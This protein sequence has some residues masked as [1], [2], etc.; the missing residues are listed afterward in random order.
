MGFAQEMKDFTA[1]FKVGNDAR[2]SWDKPTKSWAERKYETDE[3]E[4]KKAEDAS[5]TA[6]TTRKA[7]T[8]TPGSDYTSGSG[9]L[10][11]DGSPSTKDGTVA[12]DN[13]DV[14]NRFINTVKSAGLTNPYGLAAV[15][16]TAKAESSFKPTAVAG[17]WSDPSESGVPGTSGGLMSWRD[18]RLNNMNNFVSKAGGNSPEAQAK[19]FVNEDPQLIEKLQSAKST[20]EASKLMA[21]AWKYRGYD[22]DDHPENARRLDYTNKYYSRFAP[23]SAAALPTEGT[24]QTVFAAEGGL[25]EKPS[26]QDYAGP[27]PEGEWANTSRMPQMTPGSEPKGALPVDV[28]PAAQAP[29]EDTTSSDR[30]GSGG[31]YN[32]RQFLSPDVRNEAIDAGM[33]W[34]QEHFTGGSAIGQA[35]P[36]RSKK[37]EAFARNTDVAS[38]EDVK[39]ADKAIDPKGELE[40]HLRSMARLNGAYE[41]YLKK[42]D[43][44][45]AAAVAASMM[46]YARKVAMSGGTQ[47]QA[48]I[49]KGNLA[50]AAKVASRVY[51]ELPNGNKLDIKPT[52]DGKALEYKVFDVDG[53]PTDGG[54]MAID[55]FM[56][57]ATGLQ[58][59]TAWFQSMGYYGGQARSQQRGTG[60][61]VNARANPNPRAPAA[62]KTTAAERTALAEKEAAAA[63]DSATNGQI[64]GKAGALATNTP[65]LTP[66]RSNAPMNA[67]ALPVELGTVGGVPTSGNM[68]QPREWDNKMPVEGETIPYNA[69]TGIQKVMPAEGQSP[70][71]PEEQMASTM[72]TNTERT[73]KAQALAGA[74]VQDRAFATADKA[75]KEKANRKNVRTTDSPSS[76][77]ETSASIE[78][79]FMGGATDK[80]GEPAKMP[81]DKRVIVTSI[82]A[83]IMKG[84]EGIDPESA[85]RIVKDILEKGPAM[86]PDGSVGPRGGGDSVFLDSSSIRQLISAY[87]GKAQGVKDVDTELTPRTYKMPSPAASRREYSDDTVARGSAEVQRARSKN[88]A[89]AGKAIGEAFGNM[90]RNTP[91]PSP[92]EPDRT[93]PV[94]PPGVFEPRK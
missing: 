50:G 57:L 79:G 54:R 37:M 21:Q 75:Y 76:R 71:G 4:R 10:D 73:K 78:S 61:R 44:Q 89:A 35:D 24:E 80:D 3:A 90:A 26:E 72:A 17:T 77:T 38:P 25:I 56:E 70:P 12:S 94:R 51:E 69:G 28:K 52:K 16:G 46:S 91:Q 39:E 47:I 30:A 9:A 11:T 2:N 65:D 43:P 22:R 13:S 23:K 60:N 36:D 45:K 55:Q 87:G 15:A 7:S 20:E 48:L 88:A 58:N 33:R 84:N 81:A 31:G 62:P 53:T 74:V 40:P 86:K 41:F 82:A 83:K 68:V 63:A 6:F 93:R 85:G 59:G 67:G 18:N 42:G 5:E 19:F 92:A 27:V 66:D 32:P 64:A 8:N 49:E 29:A 34:I 14:E 1:A